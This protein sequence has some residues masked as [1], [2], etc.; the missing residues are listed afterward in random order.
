MADTLE[1]LD[2]PESE[3]VQLS[4]VSESGERESAPPVSFPF[5]LTDDELLELAWL[6]TRYAFEPFGNSRPRAEAAEAGMRDLGRLMFE[7]VFRS[8]SEAEGILTRVTSPENRT[9][10]LSI[11]S[12]R[13][14]ILFL[15]WE[16]MNDPE[17]GYIAARAEGVI[18]QSAPNS[19]LPEF[20]DVGLSET[21][22]NVLMLCPPASEGIAAEAMGAMESLD[23]EVSLDCLRVSSLEAVEAHLAERTGHY[24]ILHID[25]IQIDEA[26]A[27][28]REIGPADRIGRAVASAGIPVVLLTCAAVDYSYVAGQALAVGG[29]P[30]VA[31][32]PVPL[33]GVGRKLFA[34]AF[35]A[36]IARGAGAAAGVA[37]ARRAMM[38]HPHRPSAAGPMVT[39]DWITP[40]VY[41]SARYAPVAVKAEEPEPVVPGMLPATPEQP[42][43]QLPRGGPYGLMGRRREILELE[44]VLDANPLVLL[45][46]PVGI[47]KSELA[48]GLAAWVEK[49]GGRPDGVFYTNF[50]VG[51][52][53]HKVL[54]EVGTALAGLEFGDLPAAARR[55]WL[56][57]YLRGHQTLLVWDGVEN[58]AG[59]PTTGSGFLE[60]EELEELSD[61]L[62]ELSA[63]GGQSQVILVSRRDTEPWLS[64]SHGNYVLQGLKGQDRVEFATRLIEETGVDAARLGP[65]FIELLDLLEG[66]PLGME[67]AIPLIKEVPASVLLTE[68]RS[69]IEGH[70][71]GPGEDGRPVYLTAVMDHAFGRMPRR[72]RTHLPF[73]SLF[74]S[75]VM[76]DILTHITQENAYRTVMGEQLG[77]GA[78]RTM[79]RSARTSGFLEPVTPSVYQI[80]PAM[81][82]FYGRALYRQLSPG[83]VTEL[84][85]EF[86]RVY[87]DTA[88][89]F[90]ETLYE[91][92]ESGTNAILAEEG[93]LT[94]ALGLGAGVPAMGQRPTAD[95]AAG[96]GLPNAKTLSRVAPTASPTAGCDRRS[97]RRCRGKWGNR[98]VA[99]PAGHRGVRVHRD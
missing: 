19:E 87:A 89:Y 59:F 92:Q 63:E 77:W 70:Q 81:G 6:F 42:P 72:S 47:G 75:R 90:M 66:H 91:N 97:R 40:V 9:F 94:Q 71:P 78:C 30:E 61:F 39:W 85:A 16:L 11:V 4:L 51:G 12:A 99:L 86:V 48:L 57:E 18:R 62:V 64:V 22:F 21:H 65:E 23:V 60:E 7:T 50:D 93:N 24:H 69:E 83:R 27:V 98:A 26:G 58:L 96:S 33:G 13:P 46:G 1:I 84:E 74:R 79:L 31:L 8:S 38:E 20:V 15:S 88:D 41:Q 49:S 44:R 32:L 82:W 28:L 5:P 25:G 56:L 45:S 35:Y 43:R 3:Q 68:L 14:E 34:D 73:L 55:N 53:L 10:R 2:L 36:G 17:I 80:H 52:G 37:A 54:H 29:A 67:V 95:A 76:M